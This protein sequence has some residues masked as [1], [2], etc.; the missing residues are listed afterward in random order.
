MTRN[1]FRLT[2]LEEYRKAGPSDLIEMLPIPGHHPI[3]LRKTDLE[4]LTFSICTFESCH[5][6]G[7]TGTA[8]SSLLEA[9]A[10][11]PANFRALCAGLGFPQMPLR[12]FPVEM[13]IYET[14]GE[15]YQRRGLREGT[16]FDEKSR[17]VESLEEASRLRGKAYPLIWLREL[18]RVHSPSVQGGLLDM[19]TRGDIVLSDGTRINGQGVAWVADS[20]YQAEQ[21]ATH[22]LVAFDDALKR[23][24]SVNITLNY[25]SA[26][27]EAQ[28][29]RA[30]LQSGPMH[31]SPSHPD[32][33]MEKGVRLGHAI[34][35]QKAEGNLL[36]VPAP[37]IWGYL[38]FLRMA[39]RLPHLTPQQVAM[40][41]LL[42]LCSREDR[43][44]VAA[45]LNEVFGL[46]ASDAEDPAIGV[47]LF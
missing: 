34:R 33:L 37:T 3:F 24:F 41:T 28:V 47:N 12:V 45:V 4:A 9:I 7:P 31:T 22:T 26:E 2:H 35:R 13:V 44:Q 29:L 43:K 32:L 10:R 18:G 39:A 1:L 14:P 11:V 16:T 42:G 6:S 30:I 23:R 5:I 46:D 40:S 27:Q 38:A 20:N 19:M 25:L 36:S 15:L 17:L 8:K 21:D